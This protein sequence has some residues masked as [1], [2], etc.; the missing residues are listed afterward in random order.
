M[1]EIVQF[2]CRMKRTGRWTLAL[3]IGSSLGCSAPGQGAMDAGAEVLAVDGALDAAVDASA[4]RA[5]D[6]VDADLPADV[7]AD[8]SPPEDVAAPRLVWTRCYGN[9]YC[10]DVSVP[11]DYARPAG[12]RVT[13]GVLR[14]RARMPAARVGVLMLNHGGPGSSTTERVSASYPNVLGAILG[15]AVAD[16]Y[17]I[18]AV[19]WRGH[20]RSTPS[21]R[22]GFVD[23]TDPVRTVRDINPASEAS[24]S[25]FLTE[26][27]ALQ[28]RC[29]DSAGAAFLASVGAD[30]MARDMDAV[31]EALGERQITY[32]GYSYGAWLGAIYVT[33]FPSRVRAAVLDSPP[34]PVRD[35]R[36]LARGQAE[37]FQRAFGRFYAWCA[38]DERCPLVGRL[39]GPEGVE[40]AVRSLVSE[41]DAS[42]LSVGLRTVTGGRVID[43]L[44]A[45]SYSPEA[46]WV[47]VA[48]AL[49]EAQRGNATPLV[50][51]LD[52]L[53]NGDNFLSSYFAVRALDNSPGEAETPESYRM[54]LQTEIAAIGGYGPRLQADNVAFVGWPVRR[55][56]PL[57]RIAA[58]AAPPALIVSARFDAPTPY[59]GA[60]LMREA[61]GNG[62]YLVTYEGGAH[63][64]STRIPCT[65]AA[66]RDFLDAP[67]AA[68]TVTSC[69]EITF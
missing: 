24:W 58:P 15:G 69:A 54:F 53:S 25:A 17:D 12:P 23:E 29:V 27:R 34:A 64:S 62:S 3:V 1:A 30:T 2:A 40:R 32:V 33:M 13:V 60:V 52:A 4:D 44:A 63:A 57:P 49:A 6:V 28:R 19:D 21:L 59:D 45:A 31:R 39:D 56:T 18:V 65:G 14:A 9:Y 7:V 8:A 10:T 46:S 50:R 66:V 11:L 35:L 41:L 26:S 51:S 20:G 43:A 55:T 37:G 42:P 36:G 67:D 68:P 22:C 5:E 47:G 38:R 61:L 16:R 48:Q